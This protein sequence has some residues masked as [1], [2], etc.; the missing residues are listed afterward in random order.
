MGF[1]RR[2]LPASIEIEQQVPDHGPVW[3]EGDPGLLQQ[4][5]MN[6]AVN[7]RDAMPDGGRLSVVVSGSMDGSPAESTGATSSG[8]SEAV[9][10]VEDSG[11]GIRQQEAARIFEPFYTT[12]PRGK[13]TGLGL[14]VVHGIV[15]DHGGNIA[16]ESEGT[17]GTRFRIRFPLCDP[18]PA[19]PAEVVAG[20]GP[21]PGGGLVLVAEDNEHVRDIVAQA[22]ESAGYRA[23]QVG[24]GAA[25]VEAFHRHREDARLV[26]LDLDLPERSGL[27]CLEEIRRHHPG[28]PVL[29]ITGNVGQVSPTSLG[30]ADHLLEKPFRPGELLVTITGILRTPGGRE[31]AR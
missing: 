11:S 16:V 25:A 24:D 1:L 31:A 9:L 15:A 8:S 28:L 12:K 5:L 7:A 27:S 30:G 26:V 13:G 6:L 3:I 19:L 2:V 22:V 10:T 23:V 18:P 20:A 4:V 21:D 17:G 29:I 14:S